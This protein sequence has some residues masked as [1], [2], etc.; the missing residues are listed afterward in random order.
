MEDTGVE[1]ILSYYNTCQQEL[2][3]LEE[4]AEILEY[5]IK[6]CHGSA[7]KYQN[8]LVSIRRSVEVWEGALETIR[9]AMVVSV[10]K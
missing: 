10:K 9:D 3:A 2:D 5:A 8:E 1:D 6:K 7:N 4:K